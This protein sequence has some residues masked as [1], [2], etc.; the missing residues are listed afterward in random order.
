[1]TIRDIIELFTDPDDQKFEVWDN[2]KEDVVFRG[3]INDLPEKYDYAEITGIDNLEGGEF[4]WI[5]F[6]VCVEEE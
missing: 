4:G 5:T 2:D 3:Y 6:N 1:M